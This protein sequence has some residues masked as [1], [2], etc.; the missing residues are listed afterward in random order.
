[1]RRR[2]LFLTLGWVLALG[3]GTTVYALWPAS[4]WSADQIKTL[5]GLWLGSLKPL[6]P[7]PSNAVADNP[8]AAALGHKLFFDAR[9]SKNGA[10]SCAS[11]HLPSKNFSDGLPL[12]H[13]VGTT[14]RKTMTVV[15]T[16]YSPWLFWDG[17]KDSQWAQA[18]APLESP[19]E[20][21]ATRTQYAHLIGVYYRTEY[22]ALFGPLPD[23]SDRTRFPAVAAPVADPAARQAWEH[24]RPEDRETVTRVYANMGK[25]IAAYEREIMPGP[26]RF[27]RYVEALL[28]GDMARM[29]QTLTRDE[30]AGARLFIGKAHCINCHNGPLFTDNSFHNTGVPAAP[31]LPQDTGRAAGVQQVRA[32]EFNCLSRWSDAKPEACAELRFL[33]TSGAGL[34]GAFRP[35]TLRNIAEMAPYM[36]AGQF[37]TLREVLEHYSHAAP[38]PVGHTELKPLQLSAR[39]LAQLEAFLR[40]LSGGIAAPRDLLSA[41]SLPTACTGCHPPSKAPDGQKAG[42]ARP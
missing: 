8:R 39:E 15:G 29:Q 2:W 37:K 18:L 21:G 4:G 11:C 23:L 10:V 25:A 30:V 27:D 5:R 17:R 12:A 24:M 40:S 31:R 35:P 41:P 20:H 19:V 34:Q 3:V 38:G 22:E 14:N 32:D 7:D 36:H 16:A 42:D 33:V 9:L 26:S 13:G 28:Q 1:M 6:P